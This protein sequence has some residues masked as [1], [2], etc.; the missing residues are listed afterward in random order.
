[1]KTRDIMTTQPATV[2]PSDSI[3][4][5]ARSMRARGVGMMPV[6]DSP[7]TMRLMGVI[8]D[9]DITI[10]CVA[11]GHNANCTVG[12]HMTTSPL[13]TAKPGDSVDALAKK[14]ESARVRRVPVVETGD[15]LVGIVA[16]AD[17]A[18]K[19]GTVDAKLVEEVLA[20]ISAPIGV[21]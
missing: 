3:L 5:A 4:T 6:V 8:T 10:R 19:V 2:S 11:E 13:T 7:S 14:M 9:R 17:L 20:T 18:T 15:R 1:M 12:E 16:Q 21:A